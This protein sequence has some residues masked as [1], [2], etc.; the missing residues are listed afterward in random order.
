MYR[1]A[2]KRIACLLALPLALPLI[3]GCGGGGK[4]SVTEPPSRVG[5]LHRFDVDVRTGKVTVSKVEDP[6]SPSR[7]VFTGSA[8][9]FTSSDLLSIGGDAGIREVQIRLSNQS[10]QYFSNPR[11]VVSNIQNAGAPDFRGNTQVTTVAGNASGSTDGFGTAALF[12]AP[13]AV[14]GGGNANPTS[15]FISDRGNHTIRKMESDGSVTTF[16]GTAGTSGFLDGG[17]T[18][19]RFNAP[20]QIAVDSAGNLYVADSGNHA[21]R[22]I[23][24]NRDVATIA[25]TGVAG[26]TNGTGD[27]AQFNLPVGIAVSPSGDR[28]YVAEASGHRIRRLTYNHN[29]PRDRPYAYQV[30]TIAGTGTAGFVD[31]P[32]GSAQLNSPRRMAL[33]SRFGSDDA[34]YIADTSNNSIRRVK[35]DFSPSVSTV[36]GF[37]TAGSTD[38]SGSQARFTSPQGVAV[39]A[40]D[41]ENFT[42]YVTDQHNVRAIYPIAGSD[43]SGFGAYRVVTLA[44]AASTGMANGNGNAARFSTPTGLF[45]VPGSGPAA[46]VFVADTNN[47]RIRKVIASSNLFTGGQSSAVTEP[48]RLTQYFSEIPNRPGSWYIRLSDVPQGNTTQFTVQFHVPQGISGFSFTAFVETDTNLINVPA[49]GGAFLNTLAGDGRPGSHNGGG[50]NAQ[51]NRPYGVVPV[52]RHLR[53]SWTRYGYPPIRAFIIDSD[54]HR[55]RY[56]D[57]NGSVG[58][59]AGTTQGFLDNTALD[60]QFNSPRVGALAPDGT[61]YVVDVFNRRIRR[62]GFGPSQVV[63]TTIAGTGTAG[64]ADGLGN[65][66]TINIVEGI[67]VDLGGTIYLTEAGNHSVR[68]IEY[69]GFDPSVPTS[70][71]VTTIA[72]GTVGSANGTGSAAQLRNP[73]GIAVDNDGRLYVADVLNHTI[74]QLVRTANPNAYAVTTLAGTALSSGTTDGTGAAARFNTPTGVSVDSTHNIYVADFG[75]NRIRRITPQGVVTTI[76]GSTAG[77]TDG[78]SGVMNGPRHIAVEPNSGTLLFTDFNNHSLRAVERI[79]SEATAGPVGSF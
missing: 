79:L 23:T 78:A 53:E 43:L 54:N 35:L 8:V 31:G 50:I 14:T 62:L 46:T 39:I 34:L 49:V 24:P 32:G 66:A 33:T 40:Q 56:L 21:I 19:A 38:G 6:D 5:S 26:S 42:L 12:N 18:A 76:I 70:Y 45:A 30:E 64:T 58:T 65:V 9:S 28:I 25:G 47:N 22:R 41:N 52:P 15:F 55:V 72:G 1:I 68:R 51:F 71:R 2:P 74:R 48:V 10:R 27:V 60:A 20:E 61:L 63:V 11:I 7:A 29:G 17:S 67:T 3:A 69:L 75:N 59:F 44:G 73:A 16:A 37:G 13:S 57:T 4:N 77:F 36:A